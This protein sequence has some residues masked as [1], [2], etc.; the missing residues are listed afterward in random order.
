MILRNGVTGFTGGNLLLERDWNTVRLLFKKNCEEM[1]RK[2]GGEIIEWYEPSI[3]N[4]YMHNLCKIMGEELYLF[5]NSSYG[6]VAFTK[7]RDITGLM[8]IVNDQLAIAFS[9]IYRAL[10]LSELSEPLVFSGTENTITLQN[11]NELNSVEL[12]YAKHFNSR[13][14]GDLVFNY[15]D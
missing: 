14:V 1:V 2:V 7:N 12:E 5:F 3:D 11:P 13:T 15:W 10:T 4:S 6:Y 9:D 8:F